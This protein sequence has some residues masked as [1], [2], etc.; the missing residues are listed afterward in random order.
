MKTVADN[1]AWLA[2]RLELLQ[3]EKDL[4]KLRDKVSAQRRALLWTKVDQDYRFDTNAGNKSLSDLFGDS[5]QLIVQHFMMGDDWQAGC[6][7]CSFWADGFDGTTMHLKN[8]DAAFVCVSSATLPTIDAFKSRMG[9]QFDWV[10]AANSTFNQDYQVTFA[11]RPEGTP[12]HYN[13]R[14]TQFP[15]PEAPGISVF[16]KDGDGQVFHTYSCYSR[17]LDNMNVA[18]Q[19]L[20]LLPKGRS[21]AELVDSTT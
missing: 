8:R 19:Y 9:W 2:A 13:Y 6:V 11:D 4:L 16:A 21:E 5:S 14:D 7:S 15:S 17:G 10:S 3:A 20:D 1:E 18:Y 12:V